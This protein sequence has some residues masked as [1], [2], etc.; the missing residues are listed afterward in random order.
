ML[1]P[2]PAARSHATRDATQ[3]LSQCLYWG[4]SLTNVNLVGKMGSYPLLNAYLCGSDGT[5][6]ALAA[7]ADAFCCE[8][9]T[10]CACLASWE[11]LGRRYSGCA[12]TPDDDQGSWCVWESIGFVVGTSTQSA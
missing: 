3:V 5:D 11:W 2:T 12:H 1:H 4:D 6:G 10:H 7:N 8:P 9:P